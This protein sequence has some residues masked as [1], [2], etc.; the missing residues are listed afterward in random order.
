MANPVEEP[1]SN[2]NGHHHNWDRN[3]WG[4]KAQRW[5]RSKWVTVFSSHN[6]TIREVTE[7]LGMRLSTSAS[8]TNRGIPKFDAPIF[9]DL[10]TEVMK[11]SKEMPKE[12]D[13]LLDCATD[14]GS[15]DAQLDEVLEKYGPQ[16]W[17]RDADRSRLLTPNPD[18]EKPTYSKDLFYEDLDDRAM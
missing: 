7:C 5:D 16:I 15:L 6:P 17:G 11:M 18:A 12:R 4:A 1:Q 13:V 2:T 10:S 9:K 8:G 14:P 3:Q